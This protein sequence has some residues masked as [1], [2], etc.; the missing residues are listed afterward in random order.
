LDP[1]L[2]LLEKRDQGHRQNRI[3]YCDLT[4]R[5]FIGFAGE[6]IVFGWVFV[7]LAKV[8]G[9]RLG[10]IILLENLERRV[11]YGNLQLEFRV[12]P[13]DDISIIEKS[14]QQDGH[15]E[16]PVGAPELRHCYLCL[17]HNIRVPWVLRH[18]EWDHV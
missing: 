8:A 16:L 18:I 12:R 14:R 7:R 13:A 10:Q 2:L 3:F 15:C 17:V 1:D 9:P 4:L 5:V 6:A 11:C